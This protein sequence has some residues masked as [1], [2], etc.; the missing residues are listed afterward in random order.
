[1][2]ASYIEQIE[3]LKVERDQLYEIISDIV[4]ISEQEQ[5]IAYKKVLEINAELA[6][7]FFKDQD[8]TLPNRIESS[9]RL[10]VCTY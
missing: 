1:M 7:K 9:V 4:E 2:S 5:L 3:H 8:A 10:M 6:N